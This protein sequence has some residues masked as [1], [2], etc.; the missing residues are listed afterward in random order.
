MRITL[1]ARMLALAIIAGLCLGG[2][3]LAAQQDQPDKKTDA[4]KPAKLDVTFSGPFKH[5][6]LT[7]FLIH[8]KDKLQGKNY[9]LLPEAME[10]KKVS[11]YS[12]AVAGSES[13]MMQL[14]RN[15]TKLTNSITSEIYARASFSVGCFVLVPV[16]G[17]G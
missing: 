13:R 12:A 10:Q 4:P 8:G 15:W 3:Q 5:D 11:D 16:K 9:L 1:H 2:L 17:R 14:K 6:N 7:I